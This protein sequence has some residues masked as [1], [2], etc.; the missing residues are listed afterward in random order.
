MKQ[1]LQKLL[2]VIA[3]LLVSHWAYAYDF[4]KDGIYYNITSSEDRTVEVTSSNSNYNQYNGKLSIPQKVI[5]NSITYSVTS[6]GVSAFSFC[7]G[8]TEV[9]IPNSV[10]SIGESAFYYCPGLTSVTIPNSVTFIGSG[11]FYY[12]TG[13][14]SVTIPNSVTSIGE[15]AFYYCDLI[16]IV[17]ASGNS[18]YDSRDNCNAIIE[19]ATN[20]LIAGCKNT[21]IPNSVTSIGNYAFYY[22]EDLTEVTIPNSVTSI[23]ESAFEGCSKIRSIYCQPTTP[24]SAYSDFSDDVLMYATLYV[25]IGSK[26]AYEAVDPWRNFWNIEEMEFNGIEDIVADGNEISVTAQDGKIIVN[27]IKN[28]M[29]EVYNINGQLVYSGNSTAIAVANKGIYIVKVADKTFKVAL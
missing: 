7:D 17:V 10:T 4:V 16:S 25:P 29:V 28:A 1:T 21:I 27:S 6:I 13:L 14:T 11:A 15:R 24:P 5:Y 18:K 8:L 2:I 3:G 26:S 19:T 20:T 23:G 22:C 9:T 12:C